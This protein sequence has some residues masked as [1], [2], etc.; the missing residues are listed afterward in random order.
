MYHMS[1][2]VPIGIYLT[3]LGGLLIA[4]IQTYHVLLR[5][6]TLEVQVFAAGEGRATLVRSPEGATLLI[7]T[8][9]DA[10]IVRLLGVSL[11]EWQRALDALVLTG[12]APKNSGGLSA[13]NERYPPTTTL[14]FGPTRKGNSS[15]LP[16]GAPLRFS[17]AVA[18]TII[19][20]G[21]FT[22]SYKGTVLHISSSTPIGTY[23]SDGFSIQK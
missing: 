7:D 1:H 9:S 21:T 13:V 19:A 18:L 5:P 17:R 20:P 6:H 10:S 8:G 4:N 23:V 11:P 16:Y 3:L 2:P 14:R 22:L 12:P 15:S